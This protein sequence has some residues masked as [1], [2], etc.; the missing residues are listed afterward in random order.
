MKK[1]SAPSKPKQFFDVQVV[2]MAV[3][4]AGSL[5]VALDQAA[6]RLG[7]RPST[8]VAGS[9][10]LLSLAVLCAVRSSRRPA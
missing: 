6:R 7:L 1:P 9:A 2:P 5:E 8:L 10:A 4:A 3:N